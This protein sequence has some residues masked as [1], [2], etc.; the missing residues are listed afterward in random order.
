MVSQRLN[1]YLDSTQE[2]RQL[3]HKAAQLL[4]LQQH[5]EKIIPNSLTRSSRVMQLEQ[6]V[7]TIAADNSAIAAKLRQLAPTLTQLFRDGMHEVTGIQVKVQVI[8]TPGTPPSTRIPLGIK[9]QQQ[10]LELASR[11]PDSALGK[12]LRRLAGKKHGKEKG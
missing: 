9:A 1:S 11:L 7:L 2:L 5:Y 8:S 3:S 4:V 10:L 6:Q 12:A